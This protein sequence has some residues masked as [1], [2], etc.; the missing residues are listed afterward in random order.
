MLRCV[1][2]LLN[3]F[4]SSKVINLSET[5]VDETDDSQPVDLEDRVITFLLAFGMP[6]LIGFIAFGVIILAFSQWKLY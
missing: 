1:E 5:N 3:S 4:Y 6:F 2:T